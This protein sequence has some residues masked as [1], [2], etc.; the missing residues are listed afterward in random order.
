MFKP[1]KEMI[2]NYVRA[3]KEAESKGFSIHKTKNG[4]S[5]YGILDN[6]YTRISNHFLPQFDG[7]FNEISR[8]LKIDNEIVV[9][10]QKKV[11]AEIGI[12]L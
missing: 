2:L 4:L 3:C 6:K 12:T 1:N 8:T 11:F 5:L 10:S 9:K 7:N